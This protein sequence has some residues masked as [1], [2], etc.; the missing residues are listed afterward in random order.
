M[1]AFELPACLGMRWRGE[2]VAHTDRSEIALKGR[3]AAGEE[4]SGEARAVVA[5]HPR[6][7]AVRLGAGTERVPGRL[8]SR[9]VTYSCRD[10]QPRVVIEDVHHPHLTTR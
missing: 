7:R 8:S 6:R 1:P 9:S 2:Q 4:P 3:F 5:H 10:R